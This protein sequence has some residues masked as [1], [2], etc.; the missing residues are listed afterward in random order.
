MPSHK[1]GGKQ[2]A[3]DRIGMLKQRLD[4]MK[5]LL[6]Y[7]TP[8]MTKGL[9]KELKS[10]AK[11]LAAIAGSGVSVPNGADAGQARAAASQAEA[12]AA[13]GQADVSQTDMASADTSSGQPVESSGKQNSVDSS[14]TAQE[15]DTNA[16]RALL[17]DA[18]K[19]LKEVVAMMKS[20]LAQAGKEAKQD[21][22]AA[23]KYVSDLDHALAFGQSAG[24]ALYTALGGL[25]GVGDISASSAGVSLSA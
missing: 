13:A 5:S 24:D 8:Q 18:R 14:G 21:M 6:L 25:S 10:L 16:L 7:A 11:E 19:L 3:M 22:Q 9:A 17:M 20:K 2:A 12:Q 15:G 23:E 4:E 1:I